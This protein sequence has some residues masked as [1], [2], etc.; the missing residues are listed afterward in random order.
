MRRDQSV[1]G[2]R[3]QVRHQVKVS[4]Q[5]WAVCVLAW[6]A[7]CSV[8]NKV[9]ASSDAPVGIGSLEAGA[10]AP[11]T[12]ILILAE[13]RTSDGGICPALA[14]TSG[15]TQYCGDVEDNCGQ[16][17]IVATVPPTKRATTMFVKGPI[18]WRRVPSRVGPIAT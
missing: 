4:V 15:T 11:E 16:T 17:C 1:S 9:S 18:V 5:V 12:P 3:Q 13:P 8:D 10:S 2:L 6:T 7:A 14:C